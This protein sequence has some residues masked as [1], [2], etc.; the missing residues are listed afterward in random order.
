MSEPARGRASFERP[1]YLRQF[2]NDDH[3]QIVSARKA[4]EALFT[5]K[6]EV[7]EQPVS[8]PAQPVKARKSRV[9]PALPTAPIRQETVNAPATLEPVPAP[10]I[11]AKKLARL[12]TLVKY[13]MTV[14]Q[15]AEVYGVPVQKIE[16]LLQRP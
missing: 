14:S 9:L 10:E 12:R 8:D 5:P 6:R 7:T 16:E 15:V 3:E 13:G 11:S 4:A 2:H 1:Q